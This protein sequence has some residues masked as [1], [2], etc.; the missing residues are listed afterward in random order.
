MDPR[1]GAAS[2]LLLLAGCWAPA[3]GG[4]VQDQPGG[5][6]IPPSKLIR[7]VVSAEGVALAEGRVCAWNNGPPHRLVRE[8]VS[9]PICSETDASG[10][11]ELALVPGVWR[12]V[13]AAREHLPSGDSVVLRASQPHA[14]LNLSLHRGGRAYAGRLVELDGTP[15]RGAEVEA[16]EHIGGVITITD[17]HGRYELWASEEALVRA[18]APGFV[19]MIGRDD[20]THVMLPESVISGWVVESNGLPV[21]GVRVTHRSTTTWYFEEPFHATRTDANG[22]FRLTQMMPGEHELIAVSDGAVGKREAVYV[23]Y[24]QTRDGVVIVLDEPARPLRVRVVDQSGEPLAA[25]QVGLTTQADPSP[26]SDRYFT[27]EEGLIEVPTVYPSVDVTDLD[28]AGWVSMPPH[29]SIPVDQSGAAIPTIVVERGAVLRGRLLDAAGRPLADNRVWA[30]W[31]DDWSGTRLDAYMDTG[32]ADTDADGRFEL[33]GFAP[34][35][36]WLRSSSLWD[37]PIA[38][39]FDIAAEPITEVTFTILPTGRLE[40]HSSAARAGQLIEVHHCNDPDLHGVGIHLMDTDAQGRAVNERVL[41]GRYR[42]GLRGAVSCHE[43]WGIEIEV[44]ADRTQTVALESGPAPRE[45]IV[46]VLT[47]DGR[48]AANVAVA[49]DFTA[50]EELPG[51]VD[52]HRSYSFAI[53]DAEGR[54][55]V[56]EH[57]RRR[58]VTAARPGEFGR[59]WLDSDADEIIVPLV[60]STAR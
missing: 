1:I 49:T 21:A 28:C 34:A 18:R 32:W 9:T 38:P 44:V 25:C 11:Y 8:Q 39:R 33:I 29:D 14:V 30:E 15:I 54:V 57:P 51:Q 24:G 31:V 6:D 58:L 48:S 5:A 47:P 56:R 19:G 7:G 26:I 3:P 20:T 59:A 41:P 45:P 43:A 13:A 35:S 23:T 46:Q 22:R 12:V 2:M 40:V 53:T 55:R 36:Y 17:E 50:L 60:P 52:W 27:D 42:V 10:K 16:L 37:I 4:D